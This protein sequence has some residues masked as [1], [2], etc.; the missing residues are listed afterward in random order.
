LDDSRSLYLDSTSNI[1]LHNYV[2]HQLTNLT[3][4]SSLTQITGSNSLLLKLM[5]EISGGTYTLTFT[6]SQHKNGINFATGTYSAS[7]LLQSTNSTFV[8][9]L[10]QSSSIFPPSEQSSCIG[11]LVVQFDPV[12]PAPYLAK[13]PGEPGVQSYPSSSILHP[14]ISSPL[15]VDLLSI[16]LKSKTY[17][18]PPETIYPLSSCTAIETAP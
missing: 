16:L 14:N 12:A 13:A 4:G 10:V 17:K 9:K 15:P 11:A 5:T 1:F 6:G 8:S 3:S 2:H 18:N 7:I